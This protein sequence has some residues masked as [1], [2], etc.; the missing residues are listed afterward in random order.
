MNLM[1]AAKFLKKWDAKVS[2]AING[3]LAIDLLKAGEQFDLIIMDLQMP[4]MDGFEAT[5]IIKAGYP[6]IPVIAFTADA[7]PETHKKAF[8]A[9]MCDYLTKPFAPEALFEKVSKYCNASQQSQTSEI[10]DG[11]SM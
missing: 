7:M 9:G 4:V 1:I 3:Q 8:D 11:H 6:H 10:P 5:T 2:Q